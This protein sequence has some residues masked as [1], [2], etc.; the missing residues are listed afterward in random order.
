MGGCLRSSHF[1]DLTVAVSKALP[2][3]GWVY[4]QWWFSQPTHATLIDL[5][6]H[7]V[8]EGA[9][10]GFAGASTLGAVFSHCTTS[11]V[12]IIDVDEVLLKRITACADKRTQFVCRDISD[13]LDTYLK[14]SFDLVFAD[15]PW[16]SSGLKSFFVRTSELLAADGTL[17]ISFPP[18]FTRPSA[19]AERK[20]LLRMEGLLALSF[21]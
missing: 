13:P 6:L 16:S 15:P 12:T 2:E 1:G 8:S 10:I 20:A 9:R 18:V 5:L 4:S 3:P 21:T 17:V 7:V 19:I 11:P 14:S